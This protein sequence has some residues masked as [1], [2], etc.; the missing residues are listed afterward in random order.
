MLEDKVFRLLSL[1]NDR[2]R[3]LW[4]LGRVS[5]PSL[6]RA[7]SAPLV[8]PHSQYSLHI[9]LSTVLSPEMTGTQVSRHCASL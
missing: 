2:V 5:R 7:S 4:I 1:G 6:G 9:E 3:T 8:A